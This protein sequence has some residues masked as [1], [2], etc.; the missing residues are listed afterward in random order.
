[1]PKRLLLEGNDLETLLLRVRAE[2]GPQAKVVK[3]ERV[4]TGGVGG[5]FAKERF[6][7][8]VEMPDPVVELSVLDT[9]PPVVRSQPL[10]TPASR[11]PVAP[12]GLSGIDALLDAADSG[13][14]PVLE[15]DIPVSTERDT[16]A[17]VLD[18]VRQLAYETSAGAPLR[19]PDRAR[20][21]APPTSGAGSTPDTAARAPEATAPVP[22]PVAEVLGK[23]V[24]PAEFVAVR[25]TGA[26]FGELVD[27]G[28]PRGV[29]EQ[30]PPGQGRYTLSQVL[31]LV[32]KA[33]T[34]LR[35]PAS[36]VIVAGVG[37]PVI[38]TASTIAR[39]LGLTDSQISLA[40]RFTP[41]SGYGPW[42]LTGM[43]ARR[44]RAATVETENTLVVAL[45]VGVDASDWSVAAGLVDAFDP[46]Q[47]WA[48]VEADR[49][50][51]DARRWMGA[52]GE[53]RPLDAIAA[54]NV[55][56]TTAPAAVLEL[57][58]PVG[59]ID[60]VPASAVVWAAAL[61]E[62]LADPQWD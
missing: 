44:L 49:S 31:S 55:T 18:S 39:R 48:V 28:V 17:N 40:G 45:G 6:E 26:T 9:D 47:V 38:D 13:D 7:L 54:C 52:L 41:R 2:M 27:L 56:S 46:D 57:G 60:A 53:H 19:D 36:V 34:L 16:F 42:V 8:T 25:T 10:V 59:M 61:S 20:A 58:V 15:E 50:V 29:L 37:E 21:T 35:E 12:P 1:M 33:P 4:R 30:L 14:G 5:F 51:R 3:A 43:S 11:G 23:T 22:T 24:R 32:P 62:H